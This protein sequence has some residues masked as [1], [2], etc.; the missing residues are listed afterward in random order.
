MIR[1]KLM[2]IGL[3]SLTLNPIIK[4]SINEINYIPKKRIYLNYKHYPPRNTRRSLIPIPKSALFFAKNNLRMI[5][6][7]KTVHLF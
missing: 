1:N 5:K 2:D 4:Y 7:L 3:Y 6:K